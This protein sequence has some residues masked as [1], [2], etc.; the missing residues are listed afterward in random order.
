MT[1]YTELMRLFKDRQVLVFF[2]GGDNFIGIANGLTNQE[3][4]AVIQQ[5]RQQNISLKCGIG[6]AQT[7]RKAAE[8]AT[9]NLDT[10]RLTNGER[11][12]LSTT[13]L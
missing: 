11:V 5:Y 13:Q 6:I 2:L 8:L 10:I 12:L 7:A 9:Q 1:L 3:V 4:E